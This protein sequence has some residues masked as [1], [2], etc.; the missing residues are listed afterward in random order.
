M[1]NNYFKNLN[2]TIFNQIY[3]HILRKIINVSDGLGDLSTPSIYRN[4]KWTSTANIISF[5]FSCLHKYCYLFLN[6]S[7]G[8]W[9]TKILT[10]LNILNKVTAI[11]WPVNGDCT[12][13]TNTKLYKKYVH[14]QEPH[15]L[16]I[17]VSITD[18]SYTGHFSSHHIS[19]GG[20]FNLFH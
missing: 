12:L 8:Y 14:L 18:F 11:S 19:H 17:N 3:V 10:N 7:V 4:N 20:K 2:C 15:K 13:M 9:S 5:S 1:S 6:G 16:H